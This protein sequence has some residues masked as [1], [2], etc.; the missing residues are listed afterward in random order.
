MP[1]AKAA[2]RKALDLDSSLAEAHTS[3]A[4]IYLYF[5]WDWAAAER[6]FRR[7]LAINPNY[8]TAH[9]WYHEYLT[10][11]GRFD[12]QMSEILLAQELDPLSL[13]IN[14]DVGWGLYY[15]RAYDEGKKIGWRDG[16]PSVWTLLRMRFGRSRRGAR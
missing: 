13:I 9:H 8:A 3:R 15:G 12:E 1:K 14:T 16:P 11:M 10:A 7:A 2:A 5:D 4:Y 6:S